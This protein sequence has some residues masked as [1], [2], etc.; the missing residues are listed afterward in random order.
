MARNVKVKLNRR[1]VVELMKSPGVVEDLHRRAQAIAAAAGSGHRI[2][3][4]ETPNRARVA[5][6]TD[7]IPAMIREAKRQSLTRAIDAGRA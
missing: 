2:E 4:G 6:I 7:T 5:V 3:E 1:G